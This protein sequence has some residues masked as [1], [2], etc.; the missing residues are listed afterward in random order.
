MVMNIN[1][2]IFNYKVSLNLTKIELLKLQQLATD[3]HMS[4]Q[5]WLKEQI[6]NQRSQK[7]QFRRRGDENQTKLF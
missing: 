1:E 7:K 4:V 2:N 6:Y 5:D 3:N